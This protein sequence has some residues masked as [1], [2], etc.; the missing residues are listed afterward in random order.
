MLS[1][2][3]S[4]CC[5]IKMAFL[6][7]GASCKIM[8]QEDVCFFICGP[9]SYC[10]AVSGQP[11]GHTPCGHTL[12]DIHPGGRTSWGNP[13]GQALWGHNPWETCPLGHTPWGHALWGLGDTHP[14]DTQ[15][16]GTHPLETHP[17][18]PPGTHSLGTRTLE[19]S[20]SRFVKAF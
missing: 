13:R 5:H 17:G 8:L 2:H 9:T 11:W 19:T 12:G 6:P 4:I 18:T 3:V 20:C 1:H 10:W 16:G 14:G 15:S 7:P